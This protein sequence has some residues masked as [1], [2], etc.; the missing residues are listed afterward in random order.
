MKR[1]LPLLL[2]PLFLPGFIGC[3]A[4]Q[5]V[6]FTYPTADTLSIITTG[7]FIIPELLKL[8]RRE[9]EQEP[10]QEPEASQPA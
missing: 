3:T 7:A 4:L 1:L 6:C 8:R 10:E 2:L 9:R 5:A